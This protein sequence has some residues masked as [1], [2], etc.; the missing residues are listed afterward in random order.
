MNR[1]K[2]LEKDLKPVIEKLKGKD[3]S[4]LPNW[5]SK[6]KEELSVKNGKLFFNETEVIPR[7]KI[8]S[9]LRDA[10]YKKDS[11]V[12]WARDSGYADI[13]KR[14]AGISKR[15]FANFASRQRVKIR[16]DNVPRKI[17]K[18]GRKLSKKGTIEIDLYFTSRSD[19]PTVI[20]KQYKPSIEKYSPQH[21]TLTMI[22]KLT[23]LTFLSYIGSGKGTKSRKAVM[24]HVREGQK[25]FAEKLGV[26][27]AKQKY[28][29]D[30]GGEFDPTLPGYIVKL[31][32]SVEARNSFAQRVVHRLL[33]A[34][35]GDLK[36]VTRQAMEIL[37]NTK[38]KVSKKTPN[39]AA[40]AEQSEL[41]V[42]YNATRT[43]GKPT[44][45]KKLQIG[46]MVRIV[47]KSKKEL[48]Y[49]AY[50]AK[51]FSSQK[52][53]ITKVGKTKPYRY[54]VNRMWKP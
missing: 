45:E 15:A 50:K 28:V 2:I 51:Q 25:Y 53:R 44:Q 42:K 52:Y 54:F 35:R 21:Y 43:A 3:V 11:K 23:S 4:G 30:D 36:S 34:K 27:I 5:F 46:D 9:V 18:K 8:D 16:T 31:G 40:T 1:Y 33:A 24:P 32:P 6:K 38:S 10:F 12:P 22:D 14:Y 17:Q 48:M 37:N 13:S 19:L 26:P 49:K 20:Q 47:E 7:E 29:R 39:E 41:A